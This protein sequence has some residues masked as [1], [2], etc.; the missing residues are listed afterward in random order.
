MTKSSLDIL[1]ESIMDEKDFW[2]TSSAFLEDKLDD[3]KK[4]GREV[5]NLLEMVLQEP[6]EAWAPEFLDQLAFWKEKLKDLSNEQ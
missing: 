6:N 3:L 4:T 1:L 5:V 2:D